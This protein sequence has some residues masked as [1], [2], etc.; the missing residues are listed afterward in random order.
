MSRPQG[1][2]DLRGSVPA[3]TAASSRESFSPPL[4]STSLGQKPASGKKRY[5]RVDQVVYE[6]RSGGWKRLLKA[7]AQGSEVRIEDYG[8]NLGEVQ[9]LRELQEQQRTAPR[10]AGRRRTTGRF[11]TREELLERVWFY[12]LYTDLPDAGI[13]RSV[14]VSSTLVSKILASKE[15]RPAEEPH[16]R[17]RAPLQK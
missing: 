14:G 16:L 6:V 3:T 13:A 5:V 10:S 7:L 2:K 11:D 12:H 9:E 17:S 4:L 8:R 15:G 1:T